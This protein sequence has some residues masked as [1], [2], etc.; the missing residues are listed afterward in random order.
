MTGG[1]GNRLLRVRSEWDIFV[2]DALGYT[3]EGGSAAAVPQ[4]LVEMLLDVISRGRNTPALLLCEAEA[5]RH[6]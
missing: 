3:G 2:C 5:R 1:D 6:V 4:R